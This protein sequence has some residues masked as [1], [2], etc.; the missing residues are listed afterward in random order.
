MKK[1]SKNQDINT[2]NKVLLLLV[3]MTLLFLFVIYLA[4]GSL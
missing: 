3:L 4:V 2:Q 1:I